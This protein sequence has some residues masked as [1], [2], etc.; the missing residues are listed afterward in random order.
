M[1]KIYNPINAKVQIPISITASALLSRP[2]PII[3]RKTAVQND[4]LSSV[5][6]LGVE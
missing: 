4:V 6:V 1:A 5:N 2:K 3:V